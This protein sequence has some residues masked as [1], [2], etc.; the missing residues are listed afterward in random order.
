[1]YRHLLAITVAAVILLSRV[2]APSLQAAT[3][4]YELGISTDLNLLRNPD[5]PASQ[6]SA[7]WK[8]S[9]EIAVARET[10]LFRLTNTSTD[11]SITS[12]SISLNTTDYLFD[13]VVLAEAPGGMAPTVD[14]PG[15][16]AHGQSTS[17]VVGFS[18][19][20]RPLQPNESFAF[21]VDIDPSA[22][23]PIGTIDY[24]DI[25]WDRW[26]NL[27][28]DNALVEVSSDMATPK[29]VPLFEFAMLNQTYQSSPADGTTK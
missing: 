23:T 22:T 27:R 25:R 12:I 10:P 26:G 1:M 17:P 4:S 8:T 15:D 11:A 2:S 29:P 13:A 7:I 9:S 6:L 24:R 16:V 5:D 19:D 20:D 28:D 14:S 21:W 18:F 3:I